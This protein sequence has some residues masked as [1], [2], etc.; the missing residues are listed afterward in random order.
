VDD[1]LVPSVPEEQ[2]AAQD[3]ARDGAPRAERDG[4]LTVAIASAYRLAPRISPLIV[5]FTQK[6]AGCACCTRTRKGT[7]SWPALSMHWATTSSRSGCWA[8]SV[9]SARAAAA[10][11][12]SFTAFTQR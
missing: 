6:S 4:G 9:G 8:G 7:G 3:A 2:Y 11:A 5:R 10:A 12:G 1:R